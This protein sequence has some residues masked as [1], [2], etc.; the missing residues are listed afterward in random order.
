MMGH[1]C[2]FPQPAECWLPMGL[3]FSG[4]GHFEERPASVSADRPPLCIGT[5][6]IN[7]SL[8]IQNHCVHIP[9]LPHFT[10]KNTETGW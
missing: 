6:S 9:L 4:G 2:P 8:Q 3:S 5:Y 7:L 10:V 1:W